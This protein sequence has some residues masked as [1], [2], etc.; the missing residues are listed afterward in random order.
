M[1]W[2]LADFTFTLITLILYVHDKL[3]GHTIDLIIA[4]A[5]RVIEVMNNGDES[6]FPA[7]AAAIFFMNV[8]T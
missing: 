6:R 3:A 8:Q 2:A 4:P 5:K 1:L 7:A